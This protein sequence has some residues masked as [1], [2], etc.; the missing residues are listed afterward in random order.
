MKDYNNLENLKKFKDFDLNLLKVF[1]IMYIS[2]NG[3]RAS[4]ILGVTPSAVTQSLH[5][6]RNYFGDPLFM[7]KKNEM[8]ST[9]LAK[10]IHE[11]LN[12]SLG[13]LLEHINMSE[14]SS[15]KQI[16]IY[17]SPLCALRVLPQVVHALELAQLT[18]DINHIG[19]DVYGNSSNEEILT[20]R[21]ADLVFETTPYYSFST[22]TEVFHLDEAVAI[23]R[24]DHPR[25]K[26]GL[27]ISDM[28]RESSTLLLNNTDSVKNMQSKIEGFF[29]ERKFAY[30][31]S[32]MSTILSMTECTDYISF[33]PKW[34]ALKFLDSFNIKILTCDF[35][36]PEVPTYMI[37]HKNMMR[38][39]DLLKLIKILQNESKNSLVK[40]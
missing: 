36:L 15:L 37:Y 5:K 35:Q 18:C 1:E 9:S 20:F 11:N 33:V 27:D 24:K 28:K 23:C 21:K 38:N 10:S 31:S 8:V 29:G 34:F 16:T 2:G 12:Q 6:L 3:T 40:I 17:C 14:A 7:R 25:I 39:P 30:S 13:L 22:I 4:E 32:S 26:S 19:S